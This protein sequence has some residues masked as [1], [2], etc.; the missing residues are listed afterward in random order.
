MYCNSFIMYCFGG[1][2]VVWG[3]FYVNHYVYYIDAIVLYARVSFFSN[4][5]L[6]S[7]DMFLYVSCCLLI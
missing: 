3:I 2:F 4:K 7:I 1:P 6:C 5:R